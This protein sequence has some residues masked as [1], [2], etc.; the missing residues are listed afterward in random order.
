MLLLIHSPCVWER[1]LNG[2]PTDTPSSRSKEDE[3][4][5]SKE[6][7]DVEALFLLKPVELNAD[8]GNGEAEDWLL[9]QHEQ[10][11]PTKV[12]IERPGA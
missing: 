6:D 11:K 10:A 7:E 5:T 4:N 3:D 1:M 2:I 12:F 8:E 9:L